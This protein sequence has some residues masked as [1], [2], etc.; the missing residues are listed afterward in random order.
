M[1]MLFTEDGAG[2]LAV[3]CGDPPTDEVTEL[4]PNASSGHVYVLGAAARKMLDTSDAAQ[5]SRVSL[6]GAAASEEGLS[7]KVVLTILQRREL[8]LLPLPLEVLPRPHP[9][10]NR[11]P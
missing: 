3:M 5:A 8:A 10:P 9:F 6:R 1:Q 11:L 4:T 2:A 7:A